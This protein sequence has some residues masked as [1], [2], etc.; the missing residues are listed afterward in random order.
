[1][2]TRFLIDAGLIILFFI[3]PWWIPFLIAVALVFYYPSYYEI[4]VLGFAIDI[5]YGAPTENFYG[6]T[7]VATLV[8]LTILLISSPLRRRLSFY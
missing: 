1:M 3:T 2:A 7:F 4:I 6:F 8:G 5:L